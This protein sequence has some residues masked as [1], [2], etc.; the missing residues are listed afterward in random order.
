[1]CL[2]GML[3]NDDVSTKELKRSASGIIKSI[4]KTRKNWYKEN[5]IMPGN[6]HRLQEPD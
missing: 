3:H 6:E 4:V 5:N 2:T 1:M